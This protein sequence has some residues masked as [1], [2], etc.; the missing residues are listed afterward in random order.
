MRAR[1][2]RAVAGAHPLPTLLPACSLAL[3]SLGVRRAGF[4]AHILSPSRLAQRSPTRSITTVCVPNRKRCARMRRSGRE[5]MPLHGLVPLAFSLPL[6]KLHRISARPLP[7][8]LLTGLFREGLI[9]TARFLFGPFAPLPPE[10]ADADATS[11]GKDGEGAD[12][13]VQCRRLGTAQRGR[14]RAGRGTGVAPAPH[15]TSLAQGTMSGHRCAHSL[16]RMHSQRKRS[17][18][19]V[20]RSGSA[21]AVCSTFLEGQLACAPAAHA[22]HAPSITMVGLLLV[23]PVLRVRTWPWTRRRRTRKRGGSASF[24]FFEIPHGMRSKL[25]EQGRAPHSLQELVP[26]ALPWAPVTR[27]AIS[28]SNWLKGSGVAPW[29]GWHQHVDRCREG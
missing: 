19:G 2:I 18:I 5:K 24:Q 15:K 17:S 10:P 16:W 3:L 8:V 23:V 6:H 25:K 14:S 21:V 12:T 7:L 26:P 9:A 11:S 27:T 29:H 1:P 28:G 22:L 20:A 4:W 13:A